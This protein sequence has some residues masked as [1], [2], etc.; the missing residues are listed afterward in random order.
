MESEAALF[1]ALS[2]TTRLRLATL[3]AL[4]GELCVCKLAAALEAP[5]YKVSRHLAVL[6]A[7]GMVEARREGTWMYYRLAKSRGELEEG[8]QACL[9]ECLGHHPQILEDLRRQEEHV[10]GKEETPARRTAEVP[11]VNEGGT[12]Q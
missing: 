12:L 10:C 6:R 4:G 2:D 3:L 5:V 11:A 1:K 8:L 7:A 9:R